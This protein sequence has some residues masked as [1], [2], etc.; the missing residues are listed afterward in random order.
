ML[1]ELATNGGSPRAIV[2]Q[3]GLQQLGG[4]ALAP[5]VEKVLADNASLVERYKAGNPNLLGALVGQV[6]RASGGKADPKLA[7]EMLRRKL[8]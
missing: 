4:D 7:G 1:A 2:E 6:M 8:S 3:S 5:V